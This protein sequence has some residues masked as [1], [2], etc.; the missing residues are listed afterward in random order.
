MGRRL[1]AE[2]RVPR[3]PSTGCCDSLR[4][5]RTPGDNGRT[6]S[7]AAAGPAG[8]GFEV[9][10]GAYYLL[11]LLAQSAPHAIPGAV[12]VK[13][14]FQRAREGFPLDDIIVHA[15]RADGNPATLQIQAKRT[16][17]FAPK[18]PVFKEVVA[19]IA[20]AIEV[21]GF[22]D[23]D[24]QLAVATP[25]TTTN[26]AGAYQDVIKWA[27]DMSSHQEFSAR[28]ARPGAANPEMRTFVDT[29][30]ANLAE[31]GA[32][33]NDII[34]WRILRRFHILHF[35]FNNT[36]SLAE[37]FAVGHARLLLPP[38]VAETRRRFGQPLSPS[39]WTKP[40]QAETS[41]LP[42]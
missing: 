11:A 18:D 14:A 2:I 32:P 3:T 36:A 34:V 15:E 1:L 40:P 26:V 39:S 33:N 7:P 31:A 24:N 12:T 25:R 21:T 23:G 38:T 8:T 6:T 27:H 30:R 42:R 20:E 9:K 22:W 10:L 41:T 16:I 5:W 4:E 35:D 17:T 29:F 13:V 19:Q 37:G 28:L